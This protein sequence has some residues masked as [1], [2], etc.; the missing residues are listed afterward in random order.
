MEDEEHASTCECSIC[1]ATNGKGQDTA[2]DPEDEEEYIGDIDSDYP[3][4]F[5]IAPCKLL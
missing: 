4:L 1:I 2:Y 5:R 3:Q